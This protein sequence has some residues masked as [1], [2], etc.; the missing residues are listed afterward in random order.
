MAELGIPASWGSAPLSD[1]GEFVRG[2]TFPASAKKSAGDS[3]VIACLRT[4]N[5][6]HQVEL[7]DLIY[8]PKEFVRN[9]K[10][11]VQDKDI[12]ISLA[13]SAELVGKVAQVDGISLEATFGGFLGCIRTTFLNPMF[14]FLYLRSSLIQAKL[15]ASAKKTTNI[16]NLSG[17][18]ITGIDVPIPPLGEQKRIVAKIESIQEKIK[19]IEQSV[20]KAEELIGKYREALLQKAFRGELVPQ[21]PNDEPASKL[22]DRIRA[23]RVKQTDGKKKKKDDLP[24]IRPKEIPFE[25]PK[26]WEWMR[27]GQLLVDGALLEHK[28]GNHG[29][30]YPRSAEFVQAGVPYITAKSINPNGELSEVHFEY[31]TPDRAKKL[32]IGHVRDGDILFA[33]NATVGPVVKYDFK[34]ED[35]VIGTSLTCFRPSANALDRNYLF[36]A[37]RSH[38]FQYQVQ[39][40]MKQATRNQ[41]PILKQRELLL[42]IPPLSEQ[43][44]I[45][46]TLQLLLPGTIPLQSQI[47]DIKTLVATA[48]GAILSSAFSGSLVPQDP[49]E[50]TGHELLEKLKSQS[51]KAAGVPLKK[52]KAKKRVKS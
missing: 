20:K 43:K 18:S 29:G 46:A 2:I 17:G 34:Y 45:A 49:S 48:G 52:S 7:D 13:N 25:I 12:L 9:Q 28:D 36:Y 44:Q 15:R 23:D 41:V 11:I 14:L 33:H 6:Q 47:R 39:R 30:N 51:A 24:P 3:N 22:L 50:G 8:V 40:V 1:L 10:Q 31:L 27:I 19:T 35:A 42:P 5:I 4:S 21:D 26:S 16:A 37:L 32:S 38:C